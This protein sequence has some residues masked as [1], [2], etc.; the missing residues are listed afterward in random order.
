MGS[1]MGKIINLAA[2]QVQCKCTLSTCNCNEGGIKLDNKTAEDVCTSIYMEQL[3]DDIDERTSWMKNLNVIPP[4]LQ[5]GDH[6]TD[7]TGIALAMNNLGEK[8]TVAL[9]GFEITLD[10]FNRQLQ[11][12]DEVQRQRVLS[13]LGK[14]TA[15][16]LLLLDY[17]EKLKTADLGARVDAAL[18]CRG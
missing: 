14:P 1:L 17:S 2:A 10:F 6:E 4:H 3:L 16:A 7:V 11:T 12:L 9:G 18:R 5:T 13:H 8:V 15:T